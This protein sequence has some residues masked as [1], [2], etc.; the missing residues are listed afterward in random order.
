M[1]CDWDRK[2]FTMD[3]NLNR[4]V[5]HV[6]VSYYNKGLIYKG[7]RI[8]N[9]CPHCKSAI[10]DIENEYVDQ[11]T[12]LW[13]IRYPY[14]DGTGEIVVATTRPETMFGDTA[15]AVNPRDPRYKDIVG[16]NVILPLVN[17]PIPVVADDYSEMDF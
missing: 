8:V 11:N 3:D 4:A 5:K 9:W 1:S 15:V 13:S 7:K 17:R 10:S 16:K 2:A 14:E 12:S 6:F